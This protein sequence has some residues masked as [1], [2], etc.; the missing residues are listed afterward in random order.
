MERT[1]QKRSYSGS[2]QTAH[3]DTN[4]L[5]QSWPVEAVVTYRGSWLFVVQAF[6]AILFSGLA[7]SS[8]ATGQNG[9][10]VLFVAVLAVFMGSRALSH[11]HR[12]EL[13]PDGALVVCYFVRPKYVTRVGAVRSIDRD[14]EDGE[15]TVALE[16]SKFRLSP[17]RSAQGLVDALLRRKPTIVL[18]GYTVPTA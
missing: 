17:N 6:S 3:L 14:E 11:C 8:A 16:A 10:V 12:V 2:P 9:I 13:H 5:P 4:E 15:W 1:R 18:T 7:V